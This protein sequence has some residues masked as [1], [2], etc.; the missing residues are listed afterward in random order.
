MDE[1]HK[2]ET[3]LWDHFYIYTHSISEITCSKDT[4]TAK[5]Y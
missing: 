1:T 3:L 5:H 2:K 4:L